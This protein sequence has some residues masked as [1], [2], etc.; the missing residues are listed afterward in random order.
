MTTPSQLPAALN[1]LVGSARCASAAA[2]SPRLAPPR[3]R[4]RPRLLPLGVLL[5]LLL[6]LVRPAG[7]HQ[8]SMKQLQL[9]VAERGAELTLRASFDDVA[10]AV[11]RDPAGLARAELIADPGVLPTLTGW[12][13]LFAGD[14]RCAANPAT[15]SDDRDPRYL[16][17]RWSVDCPAPTHT[18]TLD[19][20]A[21]FTLDAAHTM[22]LHLEGQGAALDTVIGVDD[23]PLTVRLSAPPR[24]FPR[25]LWLGVDHIFSGADHICFVITLLLSVVIVRSRDRDTGPHRPDGGTNS[26]GDGRWRLRSLRMTLRSSALLITSFSVAHSLTLIAASLGWL[27]LPSRLVE[28]VIAASIVYAAAE[29]ALRPD[30]PRRWILVFGFGLIHGLGFASALRELLPPDRV[31]VSLLAFNLGVEVGQLVIV[32]FALPLLLGLA[33]VLRPH[34]YRARFLPLSSILLGSLALMWSIE[35]AFS[36]S[37]W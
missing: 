23:S 6:L 33:Q 14:A 7:A 31:I 28:T 22:V 8:T 5:G 4:A 9:R 19:L 2:L 34:R 21:F 15:L 35:R 16:A 26:D 20:A 29:N 3:R 17:V 37:L 25:W 1:V 36:L 24:S 27:E 11:G 18:L 12:V 13:Q 30:A 10:S 32:T